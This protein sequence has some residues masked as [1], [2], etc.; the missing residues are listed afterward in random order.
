M[1]LINLITCISLTR[2]VII[3]AFFSGLIRSIA[4]WPHQLI[5]Y[6]TR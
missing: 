4:L 1:K 5:P 6:H 3:N 2:S